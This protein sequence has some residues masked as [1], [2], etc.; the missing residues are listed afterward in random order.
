MTAS[1][2]SILLRPVGPGWQD[3]SMGRDHETKWHP[4]HGFRHRLRPLVDAG[5]KMVSY[6]P[7]SE[8]PP[9]GGLYATPVTKDTKVT[10]GMLLEVLQIAGAKGTKAAREWLNARMGEIA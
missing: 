3:V 1:T 7:W 4:A 8:G 6:H 5:A 9:P 10:V 2:D